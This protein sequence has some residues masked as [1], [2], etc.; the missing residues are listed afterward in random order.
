MLENVYIVIAMIA[1]YIS[2]LIINAFIKCYSI[3][4][5]VIVIFVVELLDMC[6]D[7]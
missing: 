6:G 7:V 2:D 1:N 5:V 4:I 3:I